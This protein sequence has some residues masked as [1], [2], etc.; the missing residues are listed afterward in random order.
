MSIHPFLNPGEPK[1]EKV[2]PSQRSAQQDMVSGKPALWLVTPCTLYLRKG[3]L[4]RRQRWLILRRCSLS[5][6]EF[7]SLL[8]SEILSWCWEPRTTGRNLRWSHGCFWAWREAICLFKRHT[9][10]TPNEKPVEIG[11]ECHRTVAG[12][13]ERKIDAFKSR[14]SSGIGSVSLKH[15]IAPARFPAW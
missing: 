9:M 5:R 6:M 10:H 8:Q 11:F 14:A 7:L 3:Y 12:W 13:G 1:V 2:H 4:A 15:K